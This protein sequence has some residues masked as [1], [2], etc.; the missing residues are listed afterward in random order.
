MRLF[1]QAVREA[2]GEAEK[3]AKQSLDSRRITNMLREAQAE[4]AIAPAELDQHPDLLVFEN[5]TVDLRTG[6]LGPHDPKHLITKMVHYD[7]RPDAECRLFL[8]T[9]ARLMG[10]GEG[11]QRL[12]AALQRIFGYA[13]TGHVI[14]K[15]VFLFIG[16]GNNGKTTVLSLLS[17]LLDEYSVSIQ[18]D[19]LMTRQP[20]NNSQSDLADLHGARFVMTSETEQGQRLAEGRLKRLTQ[21]MGQIRAVRKFQNPFSFTATFKLFVDANHRPVI[22]GTDAAIWSRLF[23][24]PFTVTIPHDE[25]DREL[26][27]RLLAEAEGILAWA[28]AGSGQWYQNG[29]IRPAEVTEA[30][31]SYRKEMDVLGR[32]IREECIT[33]P[34][35]QVTAREMYGR[36]RNW[37]EASGEEIMSANM[38]GRQLMERDAIVRHKVGGDVRYVGIGLRPADVM[39]ETV[40]VDPNVDAEAYFKKAS[41]Q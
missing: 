1:Q 14:E 8:T 32:F 17:K 39:D 3:F 38:L 6:I 36:Y 21:G 37:A 4:L 18:I 30:I 10:G 5:G 27:A 40:N 29:L 22:K 34:G 20:D 24:V 31:G 16:S 9:L 15:S 41:V 7:Y 13:L 11:A 12:V 2:N 35:L 28:V 33:D 23:T 26:P 25:I 19:S